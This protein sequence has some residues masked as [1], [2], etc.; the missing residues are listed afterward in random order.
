MELLYVSVAIP[1]L[2]EGLSTVGAGVRPLSCVDPHVHIEL[3]SA[4]EALVAAGAGMRLVSCVV[5]LVHLQLRFTTV[6]APTFGA[7]EL[8]P[9]CHVLPAVQLQ[10]AAGAE[11][12]G[13]LVALEGLEASVDIDVELE[14][15]GGWKAIAT[16]GA[17]VR[18]LP[19][20]NAHVFLQFVLV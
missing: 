12:F 3:V 15:G 1:S 9:H 16:D 8:G 10:T 17:E 5:A 19:G 13:A 11:A 14:A 4:N 7:L 2:R 20:V 6:G 18:P